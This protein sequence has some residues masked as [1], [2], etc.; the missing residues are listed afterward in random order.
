MKKNLEEMTDAELKT[1]QKTLGTIV[2]VALGLG[3]VYLGLLAY[4]LFSGTLNLTTILAAVPLMA[5]AI[6]VGPAAARL[7]RV[8][9]LIA[10]RS[11][12]R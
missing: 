11:A 6:S 12:A 8:K 3:L 5:L 1:Q 2:S 7:K 9:S 10:L 4:S